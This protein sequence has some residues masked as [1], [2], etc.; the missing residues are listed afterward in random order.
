[1][2][3][4]QL[5]GSP[6]E[7]YLRRR[8]ISSATAESFR[9]GFVGGHSLPEHRHVR[10]R[11]V[12]PYLTRS[13]VTGMRFRVVPPDEHKAKY[14]GWSGISSVKLFN[15]NDLWTTETVFICEGEIDAMTAHQAGLKAVGVAGVTNWDKNWWRIFRNRNV[16]IL[17]D[18]DDKGQGVG[19]AQEIMEVV[20]DSSL[21]A[22][23]SGHD[24]SSFVQD[25]GEQALLDLI[26]ERLKRNV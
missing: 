11:L 6:A 3:Q 12:I 13:G 22:M 14:M 10:D 15:P 23:P 19:L 17:A 4:S 16:V 8:G 18:S 1:M 21:V 9:L 20:R 5:V 25:A 24:V 26:D 7:T 2:Y